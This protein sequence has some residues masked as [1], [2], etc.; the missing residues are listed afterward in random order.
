MPTSIEGQLEDFFHHLV[1]LTEPLCQKLNQE[2]SDC[3]VFDTSGIEA[4]VTENNPKY[5]NSIIKKMKRYYKNNPDVD[6]YSMAY[7]FM[8]SSASCNEEI[9]QLYINGHFCYVYKFAIMTNAMGIVRHISFL[10]DDFKD[11]HP[12]LKVDKKSDSPDEDK[13]IGDSTALNPVLNDFFEFHPDLSFKTFIGDS[14]F[15]SYE[16]YPFLLKDCNFEQAIIPLNRR[17]S[18]SL[19]EPGYNESGWPLWPK[20]D[21]LP[22]KP[23]GICREKGRSTRFKWICSKTHFENGKRVYHCENPY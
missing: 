11:N 14:A 23:N 22:M 17:N 10:D 1:V 12:E 19:P 21:S 5:L 9:K 15:D 6:P 2:L 3:L 13:S 8:P 4:Y 20:D 16:N 7:G 18:K